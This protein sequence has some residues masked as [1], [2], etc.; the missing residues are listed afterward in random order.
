MRRGT[1]DFWLVGDGRMILPSMAV[2]KVFG[3]GWLG[4]P[5]APDF[6]SIKETVLAIVKESVRGRSAV[7]EVKLDAGMEAGEMIFAA[8]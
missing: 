8:A 4:K 5:T 1:G 3:T 7:G 2:T 6:W